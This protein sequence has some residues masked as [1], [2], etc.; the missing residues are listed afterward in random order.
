[1]RRQR[2]PLPQSQDV[3]HSQA[4]GGDGHPAA[5]AHEDGLAARLHEM[6]DVGVQADG[7]HGHD[8]E[9]LRQRFE[10]L[11]H[12]RVDAGGHC[13]R[14]DDGRGQEQQDEHGQRATQAE[15]S[16][17]ACGL[18]H[19]VPLRF[20]R[21]GVAAFATRHPNAQHQRD[22]DDGQRAGELHDSGLVERVRAGMHAVPCRGGC[23]HR[24]GVVHGGAGEQAE[25]FVGHAQRVA[26]RWED[27]GGQHVEQEDDRDGLG[28]VLVVRL[29]DRRGG[30]DGRTAADGRAHADERRDLRGH[31]QHFVQ[32]KRHDQRSG[33]G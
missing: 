2:W 21:D 7:G 22:G 23:R 8:D 25:A 13:Y 14:G 28:N 17:L 16:Q 11:E 30:R 4:D 6:H 1:M 27:K 18:H 9:E 5:E 26:Q 24:R 19:A 15:T 3:L 33:D 12:G 10:R 20:E 32:Q 31:A 29:D